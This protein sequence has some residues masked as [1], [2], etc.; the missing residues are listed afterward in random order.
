MNESQLYL[1]PD[2]SILFPNMNQETLIDHL[3][4]HQYG[5]M[6]SI[7]TRIFGLSHLETIEDA[8]QDTFAKATLAWRNQIPPNP[9]AWL[10]KAAKNR[11]I[12]LL[13]KIKAER[14]RIEQFAQAPSAMV[15]RDLFLESE[16]EDSQLRMIFTACH[17]SLHPKEQIAFALKTISGFSAKE[18]ASALLSKEETIKKRLV[19]ARKSIAAQAIS[20][21]IPRGKDLPIR[22]E[23]VQEVLYLIFNEGFHS[24]RKDMLVRKELCGEALRLCQ[25]L[26]KKERLRTGSTYALFALMCFHSARLD[27]KVN[28]KNEIVDLKNQDRSKWYAPLINL[29]SEAMTKAVAD[30]KFSGYHYEAAIA[31]EHLRA[32]TFEQT[33]WQK[34]VLWYDQLIQLQPTPLH[35]LNKA[36]VLL[37]CGQNQAAYI[38]LYD[39][40]ANDFA[41]RAYLYYGTLAEY[42]IKTANFQKAIENIDLAL[43]LVKNEAERQFLLAKKV[44]LLKK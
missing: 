27:S 42:F 13:R 11:A 31:A 8:V 26:L 12:D 32:K 3:F 39:L 4:R 35:F 9:E 21:E 6:V 33:D 15:L 40:N 44:I 34:I 29:G 43:E 22:L 28:T 23:Q 14:K 19:R 1:K 36:I 30:G 18:I 10:T 38:I 37:Q 5:R 24:N 16:I 2:D 41:Q 25:F 20:F 7:L 17:P